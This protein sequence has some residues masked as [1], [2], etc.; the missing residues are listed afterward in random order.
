MSVVGIRVGSEG[1][2]IATLFLTK[3]VT[4]PQVDHFAVLP[5]GRYPYVGHVVL[6]DG[7]K[8]GTFGLATSVRKSER[9][10]LQIQRQVDQLTKILADER[11]SG[12]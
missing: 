4:W 1:V 9:N 7:R 2:K 5:I 12:D 8:L 6:R 10:R 11:L 3:S